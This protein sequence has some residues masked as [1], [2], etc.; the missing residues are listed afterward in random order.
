MN[1][2]VIEKRQQGQDGTDPKPTD[3]ATNRL[4]RGLL[5]VAGTLSV[6]LGVLGIFLPLLPTTPFLLIAAAC[7]AKSS[8]R[9]YNWLL[10]NKWFGN[11]IKDYREKKGIPRKVKIA[12]ISLLWAAITFS[13]LFATDNLP[14]RIVLVLIATS[15]T[16]HV[17]FIRTLRK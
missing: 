3:R 4:I 13:T 11:Y 6:G 9:F 8:E 7:Y 10:G 15:V 14:V 5:I 16:V 17:L 12:S 2:R 1:I